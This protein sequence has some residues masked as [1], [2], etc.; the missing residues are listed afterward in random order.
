MLPKKSEQLDKGGG[1][2]SLMW[3]RNA[4]RI[5]TGEGVEC[6]VLFGGVRGR[7]VKWV[8]KWE[9]AGEGKKAKSES[10]RGKK[11]T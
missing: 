3:K 9:N 1:R 2:F 4:D 10:E 5:Q 6:F 11:R 8:K 7:R